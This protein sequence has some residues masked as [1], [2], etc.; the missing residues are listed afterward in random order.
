MPRQITAV[1]A[2]SLLN[3]E[4]RVPQVRQ[5]QADQQPPPAVPGSKQRRLGNLALPAGLRA[6]GS[7]PAMADVARIAGV[8]HQT[9]SRV[10]NE[11]D[12][13]RPATRARVRAAIEQLGYLPNVAARALA[14]GRT[15]TVGVVTVASRLFGPASTLH[16]IEQ[17]ARAEG[18]FVTMVSLSSIDP[19]SVREAIGRL[20]AQG[21]DGVI[22]DVPLVS[23]LG[24]IGQLSVDIPI[25]AVEGDPLGGVPV[26]SVDQVDGARQATEHLL[27]A[28]HATVWHVAGPNDWLETHGRIAGWRAALVSAAA[29][30]PPLLHGDWSA[31]SGYEA[32]RILA[33][34][35][36]VTAVFVANDQ[37]ALG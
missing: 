16:G 36:K 33:S 34:V 9:V 32:G 25:V 2:I 10:V 11:V 19:G 31:K 24:A 22:V 27:S 4:M 26:V 18:Y 12:R 35:D 17:A 30:V 14:T 21:V 3:E 7:R 28:G 37:M 8:S 1:G 20:V 5:H 23:A 29:H 6:A 15:R 13:V